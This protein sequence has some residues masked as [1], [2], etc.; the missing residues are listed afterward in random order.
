MKIYFAASMTRHR[1]ML[2]VYQ[3]IVGVIEDLGHTVTSKHVVEE[4]TTEGDWQR[5]Y[6]P[7]ELYLREMHRLQA[8]DILVA[9]VTT[10]SWGTAFLIDAAL[11]Q[12]KPL[13][14]LYYGLDE[15]SVPLM[16]RGNQAINLH[17]YNE[18]SIREILS[19]FFP[20][21]DSGF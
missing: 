10:P 13:I 6:K 5:E 11:D 2:P 19:A 4:K 7:H 15:D 8:S 16:L 3:S 14:C 21:I 12:H 18:D 17:L 1:D 9:D 20:R